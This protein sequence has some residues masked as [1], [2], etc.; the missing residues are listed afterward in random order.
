MKCVR[1]GGFRMVLTGEK[2]IA[3]APLSRA[4]MRS[5]LG[6]SRVPMARRELDQ[7]EL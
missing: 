7:A 2:L 5:E 6:R 1:V 3:S 4:C